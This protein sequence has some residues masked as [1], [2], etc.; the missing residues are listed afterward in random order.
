MNNHQLI[1]N[2]YIT[3]RDELLTYV[4][5]R[6]G[7]RAEAEDV[8]QNIFLH[9][10]SSTKLITEITLPALVYTSARH[11]ICDYYRRRSNA[12]EYEHYIRQVCSESISTD[13]VCSIREITEQMECGLARLPENC[14]EVYRLHIYEGMKTSEISTY[15]GDNYKSVEYRLGTA[16]KAMRR[17]LRAI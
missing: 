5:T 8:I 13:T 4:S 7:G 2:Y 9:L 1:T 15:L 6:L 16:R 14:R 12:Y 10:L 11:M 3:H 17:Y